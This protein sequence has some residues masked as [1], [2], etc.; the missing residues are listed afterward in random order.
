MTITSIWG[1][2]T[3]LA[4]LVYCV[5]PHV[6]HLLLKVYFSIF[7]LL[8]LTICQSLCVDKIHFV[9]QCKLKR[10]IF[11]TGN[12][13]GQMQWVQQPIDL[14]DIAFCTRRCWG[15][16]YCWHP[17]IFRLR[18]IFFR[19]HSTCKSTFLTHAMY[20]HKF[21][22]K[23]HTTKCTTNISSKLKYLV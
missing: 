13:L 1:F 11:V 8:M 5:P 9:L 23:I 3:F 20:L 10:N 19:T 22:P 14:W 7:F 15:S 16:N 17:Q 6:S 12:A 2:F 18:A 4:D 21:C